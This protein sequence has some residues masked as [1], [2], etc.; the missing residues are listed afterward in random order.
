MGFL[1]RHKDK[2]VFQTDPNRA[3]ISV[4]VETSSDGFV[5]PDDVVENA[6]RTAAESV[7]AVLNE[8]GDQNKATQMFMDTYYELLPRYSPFYGRF[9]GRM[10]SPRSSGA[11]VLRAMKR[12]HLYGGYVPSEESREEMIQRTGL[13][14][15]PGARKEEEP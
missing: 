8:T 13:R 7:R 1:R 11:E 4:N 12:L 9:R 15:V 6:R 5:Y 14:H 2:R 3:P 10:I